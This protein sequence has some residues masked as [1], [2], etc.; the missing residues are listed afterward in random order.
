MGH[1]SRLLTVY[2][3]RGNIE[4]DICLN[5]KI[6]NPWWLKRIRNKREIEAET[7]IHQKALEGNIHFYKP[8]SKL[9]EFILK[10]RDNF[11]NIEFKKLARKYDLF[12]FD[13]YHFHGGIDFFRDSRW[14]K[15]L[16][17]MGK[18]IICHYHGPD[19]RSRGIVKDIDE[20]SCLN[21]TSEY[22]LLSLHPN[23]KYL[24]IPFDCSNLPQKTI[25]GDKIRIIHSPSN[26]QRKG[27][28]IIEAVLQKV[29]KARNIEYLIIT[30]ASRQKVIEEKMRSHIAIDQIGNFG[31]TGYGVNSLETLA[32]QIPTITEFT[33]EYAEF[34]KGHPFILADKNT[35]YDVLIYLIDNEEYRK[36]MGILGRQW[37][38]EHHSY[39]SVWNTMTNYM[40]S[41]IPAVYKRLKQESIVK[42]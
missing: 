28:H 2:K 39:K 33:K 38:L 37:V 15:K 35:L 6:F 40:E 30:G 16:N 41:T 3:H 17:K 29:S 13:I 1:Y 24:P 36:K 5:K 25:G 21:L 27:T 4:E 34:L 7:I 19:I 9:E 10:I 26:P 8:S 14:V 12:E 18:P 20:I 31:G 11:R 42:E 32:M 23:L 22:D